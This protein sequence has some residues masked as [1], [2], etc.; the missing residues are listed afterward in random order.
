MVQDLSDSKI[1]MKVG[2]EAEPEEI[3]VDDVDIDSM[4]EPLQVEMDESPDDG[5]LEPPPESAEPA[6]EAPVVEPK[7]EVKEKG[8]STTGDMINL[9]NIMMEED[10]AAPQTKAPVK[11]S[12]QQEVPFD[13]DEAILEGDDVLF[14]GDEPYFET[15]KNV[16]EELEAISFWLKELERQR[17]STTEKNMMEVFD[18]F[19]KGVEE[20]IGKEDYDTRYNLGIAYKE[21]GLIEEAIHEFL[22]SSKHQAKFFDSAGLLG[23]CFR[24]KGMYDEAIGWFDKGMEFPGRETEEYLALKY[25]MIIT[26]RLKED[27]DSAIRVAEE[28]LGTNAKYR[29]TAKLLEELKSGP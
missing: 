14:P 18:E 15:E 26:Y 10:S 27:Y 23:M 3:K 25:E 19:K 9:D 16:E 17:T 13:E 1:G 4:D 21:M 7:V 6:Q 5:V 24:E 11:E 2:V 12:E 20:K 8:F 28:I 22:I 29:D